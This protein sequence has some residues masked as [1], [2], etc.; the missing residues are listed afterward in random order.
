MRFQHNDRYRVYLF[1]NYYKEKIYREYK[2]RF[3]YKNK[4]Y[5]INEILKNVNNCD[6]KVIIKEN[7]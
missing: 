6:Y 7:N 2:N 4:F 5:I 3:F 1:Y